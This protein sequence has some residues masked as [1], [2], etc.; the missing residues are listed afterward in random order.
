MS[1][2][3]YKLNTGLPTST[4]IE[5]LNNMILILNGLVT[6]G[7]FDINELDQ[8][9]AD[10]KIFSR[11]YLRNIILGNTLLDYTDWSHF[12]SQSG[13]SIWKLTPDN[14]IYSI[15]NK[16][17][18]DSIV[19]DN[20]G[21]ALSETLTGFDS[22]LTYDGSLYTDNTTEAG[23]ENGT[24][25]SLMQDTGDYIFVGLSTKYSGID[26]KWETRGSGY[27]LKIE[28]YNGAWTELTSDLNNLDDNT[29]NFI[30]EGIISFDQPADW[31]TTTVNG[32]ADK[33]WIRISTTST[34]TTVAKS[35]LTVPANNVISIL[36]LS[37]EEFQKEQWAWCSYNDSIYVTIRNTGVSAYEGDAFITS[38]SSDTNI[39]NFF[40]YNHIFTSDYENSTFV[41]G[42]VVLDETA[43]VID[44]SLGDG[45]FEI[46]TTTDRTFTVPLNPV[47]NK[48]IIIKHTA[49]GADN[50]LTLPTTAGG[51]R[52]S[53]DVPSMT[54]T[55]DG[56]TDYIGIMYN[57]VDDYWDIVAYMKGY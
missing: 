25:F 3:I 40:I 2:N 19:L 51:Y 44:A 55:L 28:Y 50:L 5:L 6:N 32:V 1:D 38:T 33:Y 7:N 23:T 49:S 31:T 21:E 27:V 11:K 53:I 39:K 26:F 35:Y 47:A 17:Y 9:F 15:L 54:D 29:Q 14:Y 48:K 37:S 46:I 43:I 12:Y 52:F 45:T 10:S 20:R 42:S 56:T 4:K 13:Y 16:L 18:F 30:S 24:E 8:I 34:P 22:V 57:Q 41:D 36:A